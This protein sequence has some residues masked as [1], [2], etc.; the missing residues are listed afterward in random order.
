MNLQRLLLCRPQGGL[1]DILC[2]IE[3]ACRY[4]DRFDRWVIVE[5]DY[6]GS[7][8]FL[9]RF[10]NYFVSRQSRLVLDAA[11]VRGLFDELDVVPG[12]LRGRVN[13]YR[14]GYDFEVENFVEAETLAPLTF[15]LERDYAQPLLVRHTC[16]GGQASMGALARLRVHDAIVDRLVQRLAAIGPSY[17]GVH[18]RNTEYQTNYGPAIEA[19][20]GEIAGPV[21][22]A[23]DNRQAVADCQ[24]VFGRDR[25]FSFARLPGEAGRPPHKLDNAEGAYAANSDAILDL[26]TLALADRVYGFRLEANRWGTAYSGFSL[27]AIG[28]HDAPQVLR[29]LIGRRDPLLDARLGQG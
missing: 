9:D 13:G 21:F 28:L 7:L 10:A 15:D 8:W 24:A 19:L 26:L 4:A 14:T 6:P 22:V 18:I 29:G 16:G 1:N 25:V 11:L 20:A 23:S 12:C 17:A 2:Q 5:T 3:A 27:L